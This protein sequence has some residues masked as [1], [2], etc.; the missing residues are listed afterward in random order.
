MKD[1]NDWDVSEFF[2]FLW[3]TKIKPWEIWFDFCFE[4]KIEKLGEVPII[5]IFHV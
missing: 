3:E 5:Q 4:Q 2:K 1:L